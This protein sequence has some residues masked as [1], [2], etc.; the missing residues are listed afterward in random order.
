MGTT[1]VI[2]DQTMIKC[3]RFSI[4]DFSSQSL[5]YEF[6]EHGIK[7][8]WEE[9]QNGEAGEKYKIEI[10]EM[11]QCEFDNLPEFEGW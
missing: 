4:P 5:I 6:S 3:I 10:I 1:D 7:T 2:A 9:I 8:V 11:M